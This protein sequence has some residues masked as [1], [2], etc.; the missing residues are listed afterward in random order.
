MDPT[1]I[2]EI[3]DYYRHEIGYTV[4]PMTPFAGESINVTRAGVH[5]DGLMKD[6]EIYNIFD[7]DRILGRKPSVLIGSSSGLAGIAY[8][9]NGHYDLS[10]DAL[11]TKN[12]PLVIAMKEW[13]DSEYE[14]GRQNLLSNTELE[15]KVTELSGGALTRH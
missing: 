9:I 10:G 3:A 13:V 12:D 14:G 8:W 7:T 11:V 1:V 15:Q 5:A 2:T 4:P 6:E